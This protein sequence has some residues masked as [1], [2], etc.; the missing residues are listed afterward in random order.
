MIRNWIF[1]VLLF[2][3]ACLPSASIPVDGYAA[4]VNDK[5]ITVSEVLQTMKPVVNQLRRNCSEEE[6]NLKVEAA[7]E[8]TLDSLIERELILALYKEQ[9]EFVIP[10]DIV[11]NRIDAI[12]STKFDNNR[13]AFMR[14]LESDGITMDEWHIALK[15]RMIVS[16]MRSQALEDNVIVSPHAVRAA[17]EKA[18][19]KYSIPEQ[20][21]FRMIVFYR[22]KSDEEIALKTKQAQDVRKRLLGGEQFDVLAKEVSEGSKA[23]EGGYWG[24]VEPKS[25][26]K[27]LAQVLKTLKPGEINEVIA[28]GDELYI[29]KID[30]R[31]N[32]SVIPF[33]DVQESI[34]NELQQKATQ[35]RYNAW[36]SRLKRKSYIKKF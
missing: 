2:L 21:E 30:G 20:V 13:A 1:I 10:D 19:D 22:G 23:S 4:V 32:A 15:K 24:W 16:F 27:E 25:R 9:E 11:G 33:E 31:K 8:K 34:R 36:I 35:R 18:I 5:V 7:Y 29:L 26:R 3:P 14:A 12:I 28:A 6:L 17:Y